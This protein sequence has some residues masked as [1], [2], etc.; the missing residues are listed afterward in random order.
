[1]ERT[2]VAIKEDIRRCDEEASNSITKKMQEATQSLFFTL[3]VDDDARAAY[4]A[5]HNF[6]TSTTSSQQQLTQQSNTSSLDESFLK[7]I[8]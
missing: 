4:S 3:H 1:M 2:Q 7:D 6:F 5:M 8:I